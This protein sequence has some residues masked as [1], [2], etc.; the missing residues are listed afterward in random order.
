MLFH[1]IQ[2]DVEWEVPARNMS[3]IE[4]IL[5]QSKPFD[6]VIV[7]PE[8]FN[9]G[10]TMNVGKIAETMNGITVNWMV[11]TAKRYSSVIAGSLIIEE[12]N[13]YYN[14]FL[15]TFPDGT[16]QY[17]D[18]RHLFRMGGEAEL[19]SNGKERIIINY[20][21]FRIIPLICYDLRFPVWSRNCNDY[22]II[23][24]SASWPASR[25]NVWN[26]LLKARAIENQAFV[27]GINRT[28]TDFNGINYK[29]QSQFVDFKGDVIKSAESVGE[30]ILTADLDKKEL[31]LFREKFPVWKD[32][33][34]FRLE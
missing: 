24:Y 14:R 25:Q 10:F 13:T 7:L 31:E 30:F 6:S 12:N 9:S 19:F 26:T 3:I 32:A 15:W 29:G 4:K 16:Y 28:G 22:D 11:N 27:M 23:V 5:E 21:G 17:Y 1:L 2:F 18:K 8:M 33:D 20:K 34:S